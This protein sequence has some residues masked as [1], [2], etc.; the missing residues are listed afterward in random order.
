ML[1]AALAASPAAALDPDRAITQ[2][3][4]DHWS[5]REGLPHDVV[6][7]IVQTRDGYLWL[8]TQ[9]GLARFDGH[10]FT[11]FDQDNT[12]ELGSDDI[13]SVYEAVDGTLWIGTQGAGLV[14]LRGGE[15][16][17]YGIADG[18]GSDLIRCVYETT[19]GDLWVCTSVGLSRRRGGG[20]FRTWTSADGLPADAVYSVQQDAAGTL[21]IATAGGVARMDGGRISAFDAGDAWNGRTPP[22]FDLSPAPDGSVFAATY[23]GGI[24]HFRGGALQVIDKREAGLADDRVTSV[25]EDGDGNLWVATYAA[26]LQRRRDG[27]WEQLDMTRGLA[28][29]LMYTL[30][31]DRAGSLWIGTAGGGLHR[32]RGGPVLTWT[33]GEGLPDNKVFAVH[34]EDDGSVWIGMEGGGVSRFDGRRFRTLT[35]ADGLGSDN[36]ISLASAPGGGLWIGTFSGGLSLRDAGG[37]R[38]WTTDDGLPANQVFSLF[39]DGE[40]LWVGTMNGLAR[41]RDGRFRRFGKD[42]GLG[43]NDVRALL[44]GR[45]GAI[46][47]GTSGGGLSRIRGEAVRTWSTPEGLPGNYVY[48]LYEDARGVLWVG[49][50][51]GG[52][53]RVERGRITSVGVEHGLVDSSI[54]GIVED[55]A[56][57]LW[58]SGPRGIYRAAL[59]DLDAVAGGSR[60]GLEVERFERGSGLVG[61]HTVGG[62]QPAAWK[63]PDGRL[64]FATFDGL[65][66]IDPAAPRAPRPAPQV[67]IEAVQVDGVAVVSPLA[68]AG[69]AAHAIAP[70]SRDLEIHYTGVDLAAPESLRF[71]Y[72]L[73][74]LD[75]DWV[76]AGS[77]RTAYFSRLPPGRYRFELMVARDGGPWQPSDAA[78]HFRVLPAWYQTWWFALLA[79]FA[80]VALVAGL[81]RL[82]VRVLTARARELARLVDERTRDLEAARARFEQMSRTDALT[83]LPNRRDLSQRLAGE[84]ARAQ[85]KGLMLAVV[86]VDVDHFKQFNDTHGHTAGD[87]C[88]QR[89]AAVLEDG[90]GRGSDVIGRWGGEEFLAL[91]PDTDVEGAERVG[92]RICEAVAALRIPHA[93]APS[94]C[95]SIS[96]GA[97]AALAVAGASVDALVARADAALYRAKDE[98]RNRVVAIGAPPILL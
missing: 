87:A 88:L 66:T 77:R 80:L 11:V 48:A 89:I 28:T 63:A 30:Y 62:S 12:P 19:D 27:R 14:S 92:R 75:D 26:G 94:G 74:G 59:A 98:G 24:A 54:F 56:G 4:L 69:A 84:W 96:A 71:R 1:A 52:L 34:G 95:V 60:P 76:D 67:Y 35:S 41:F 44:R 23:G 20:R 65:A 90:V 15:F 68:L 83:G 70:R 86:L 21:W 53:G 29:N 64:W 57:S 42:E 43:A 38:T 37:I 78:W 45:D 33:T 16:T 49:T 58:L 47:A 79:T 25:H 91:L 36:V 18:L 6:R 73:V 7:S 13:R 39:Q 50:K 2:Y 46:W 40:T 31:E 55:D 51:G 8:A 85:R 93:G 72:R 9:G 82:R 97:A 81:Y 10:A 5:T 17:R 3:V 22:V 32:L 61:G